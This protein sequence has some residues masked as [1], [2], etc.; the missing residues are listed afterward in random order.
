M[1]SCL[2][3]GT[4]YPCSW[5]VNTGSVD[6]R[7]CSWT[8][9]SFCS[10]ST[11]WHLW[12]GPCSLVPVHTTGRTVCTGLNANTTKSD[13]DLCLGGGHIIMSTAW[14]LV[15][16]VRTFLLTAADN[17]HKLII[18]RTQVTTN[19]N[20]KLVSCFSFQGINLQKKL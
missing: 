4:H 9:F 2:K 20:N 8:M 1:S 16:I 3:S 19:K 15:S 18:N 5:P 10:R 7:P 6:R 14:A 13:W 11:C 12:H 17:I